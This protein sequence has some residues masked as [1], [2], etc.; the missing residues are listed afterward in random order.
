MEPENEKKESQSPTLPAPTQ[1]PIV[2][3]LLMGKD[4]LMRRNQGH[5][6]E[7]WQGSR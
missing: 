5:T 2:Q 3:T 6:C 1:E 7:H 4:P